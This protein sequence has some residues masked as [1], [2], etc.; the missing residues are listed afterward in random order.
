MEAIFSGS[1]LQ[2]VN[3]V[4]QECFKLKP[5]PDRMGAQLGCNIAT[6]QI[7][8]IFNEKYGFAIS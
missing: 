6:A 3:L 8:N 4:P 1:D 7:G 2:V 5:A